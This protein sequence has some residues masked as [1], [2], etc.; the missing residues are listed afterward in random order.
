MTGTCCILSRQP[1]TFRVVVLILNVHVFFLDIFVTV[2]K[3]VVC[4][5][6]VS[7]A[8]QGG[9]QKA[10]IALDLWGCAVYLP[11]LRPTF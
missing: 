2:F 10:D 1:L 6:V 9:L 11:C 7:F 8:S 3:S 4:M 5:T